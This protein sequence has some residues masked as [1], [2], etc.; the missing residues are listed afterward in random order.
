MKSEQLSRR[1]FL[2]QAAVA[3][4]TAVVA[5][6]AMGQAA[7]GA[8]APAVAAGKRTAS[9]LVPL[10]KKGLKLSRLGLGVLYIRECSVQ[11]LVSL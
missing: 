6:R 7:A 10:G 4:G 9:D 1:R 2:G 11:L 5:G 3:V 8:A